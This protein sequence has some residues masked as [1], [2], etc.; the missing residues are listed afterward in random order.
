MFT[1][2]LHTKESQTICFSPTGVS[3]Q[4]GSGVVRGG[5]AV[6][7]HEGSTRVPPAF[8]E[9]LRGLRG[10]ASTKKSPH[11]VGDITWAYFL[12]VLQMWAKVIRVTTISD[13]KHV[14]GVAFELSCICS[15]RGPPNCSHGF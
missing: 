15:Q 12:S 1:V 13:W 2:R 7:F 9:V 5:P 11:A 4:I 6:R 10:G 8:H 14:D 3:A